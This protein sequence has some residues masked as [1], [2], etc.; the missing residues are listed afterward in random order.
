MQKFN[1]E[2]LPPMP[3]LD[4]IDAGDEPFVPLRQTFVD[5]ADI[6]QH[7]ISLG[8]QGYRELA[9]FCAEMLEIYD[10]HEI[11]DADAYKA[12]LKMISLCL[13]TLSVYVKYGIRDQIDWERY[14]KYDTKED[15]EVT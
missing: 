10:R 7:K 13:E 8:K 3:N 2:E 5:L 14:D 4:E 6:A 11:T 15:Q 12:S 1:I 9:D